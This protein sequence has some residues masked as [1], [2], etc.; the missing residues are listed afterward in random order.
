[1]LNQTIN[2]NN[3]PPPDILSALIAGATDHY[4][5]LNR[6]QRAQISA[7]E[8]ELGRT[9][10]Q[11]LSVFRIIGEAE[12]PPERMPDKLVEVAQHYKRLVDSA[13]VA[14]GDNPE[15]A[16]LKTTV[17]AALDRGDLDAADGTYAEVERLQ[18]ADLARRALDAAATAAQRAEIA[19][20][21]LRFREA[22]DHF[23]AAAARVPP[24]HD[25]ERLTYLDREANSLYR[26]GE[27]F[28]DNDALATAIDR[29]RHLLTLCPRQ[30]VPLSW[31]NT[32]N[33]LGIALATLGERESGTARLKAAVTA[34]RAALEER[35]R[36]RVPLAWAMTQNNLANALAVL[37]ERESGTAQLKAAVTAYRAALEERTRERV[38]LAWAMTQNNLGNA[39][40]ALGERESGTARL[41]EA[42]TAYRAALEENTRE[43]VPLAWAVTQNNLG[44]A[45]LALGERESGTAQLEEAVTAYRDALREY[46]RERVPLD[47]A[48]TQNNLGTTLATLGERESGTA[49][50]E[51]AVTAYRNALEERTRERVPL[52]WAMTQNNL[53]MALTVLGERGNRLDRL[54]EA[55][56]AVR[57]AWQVYE[58]AG[59]EHHRAEFENRIHALEAAIAQRRG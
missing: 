10:G 8:R 42:V 19:L 15:I 21:R 53:G 11:M 48:M 43:R 29:N 52:D 28:G 20:T 57:D 51:A 41:E 14:V 40:L 27:E 38:P 56:A 4:A 35:T 18:L 55:L 50:L 24:G 2:V 45:L 58:Q 26:Q 22:A 5:Q 3:V 33:N 59:F 46:T 39:L 54:E 9:H 12:V 23:A 34:Y 44:N 7:L 13:A 25:Q 30:R 31:A 32:Q 1:M 49:R 17:R 36:E 16:A 6:E 47:W 37:G